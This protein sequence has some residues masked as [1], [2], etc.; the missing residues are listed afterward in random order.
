[1]NEALSVLRSDFDLESAIEQTKNVGYFFEDNGLNEEAR[2]ALVSEIESLPLLLGDHRVKPINDGKPNEVRQQHERL[3]IEYG[4][5][6]TPVAN[7]VINA[8]VDQ[9]HS[10][11]RFVELQEW[12][13]VEIGYQ[14]YRSSSDFI[15]AH[16]DRESDKLLSVTFTLTGSAAVEVFEPVDDYWDYTNLRKMDEF[17]TTPGSIML[18]RAPGL[19]SG[20]Q[21]I[22]KVYPP[23]T[24]R[25]ILNLRARE[26][27]LKKPGVD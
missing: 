7:L 1:M 18:L 8:L 17:T 26:T 3:Y 15:S 13:P 21:V 11:R 19:G 23:K 27:I 24:S 25:S 20:E 2:L 14:H 5:K 6:Q 12:I 4:N 22:H 10:M 16:R 9:V